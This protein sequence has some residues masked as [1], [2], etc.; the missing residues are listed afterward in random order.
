[1]LAISFCWSWLFILAVLSSQLPKKDVWKLGLS[2]DEGMI[3]AW[4]ESLSLTD[5]FELS[6]LCLSSEIWGSWSESPSLCFEIED[7]TPPMIVF[8]MA[9]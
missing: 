5:S 6:E 7:L 4:F 8:R 1:M 9:R 2:D 3:I